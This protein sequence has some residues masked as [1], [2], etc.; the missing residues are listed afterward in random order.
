MTTNLNIQN[1][2]QFRALTKIAKKEPIQSFLQIIKNKDLELAKL[3]ESLINFLNS[4][5]H[6][7]EIWLNFLF[8]FV[9]V[10]FLL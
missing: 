3:N 8:S 5:L 9:V 2:K 1:L 6:I 7:F 10:F 4:V